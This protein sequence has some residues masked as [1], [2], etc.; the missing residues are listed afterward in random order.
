M[1]ENGLARAYLESG[2]LPISKC[3]SV[4]WSNVLPS[5]GLTVLSAKREVRCCTLVLSEREKI[6][7]RTNARIL[8][9][10]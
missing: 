9:S 8:I 10:L 1:F 3:R 5:A 6:S 2:T 7:L 4:N